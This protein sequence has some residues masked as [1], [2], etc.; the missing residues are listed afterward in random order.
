MVKSELQIA[1]EFI[2]KSFDEMIILL[3]EILQILSVKNSNQFDFLKNQLMVKRRLLKIGN[4]CVEIDKKKKEFEKRK[5]I[6]AK[7]KNYANIEEEFMQLSS[8]YI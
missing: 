7:E 2:D 5:E 6:Y 4:L 8:I 3:S 1:S